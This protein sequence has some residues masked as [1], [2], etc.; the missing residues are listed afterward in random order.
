MAEQPTER[1]AEQDLSK[2]SKVLIFTAPIVCGDCIQKRANVKNKGKLVSRYPAAGKCFQN[3]PYP[4][5]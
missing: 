5:V 2:P 3:T 1:L 4:A